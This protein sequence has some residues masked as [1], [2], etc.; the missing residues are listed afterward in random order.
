MKRL[1][2]SVVMTACNHETCIAEAV[3]SVLSKTRQNIELIIVNDGFT[4]HAESVIL[5][6]NDV[7]IN[8]L[9]QPN[10]G[11]HHAL[12][13]RISLAQGEYIAILN[14]DDVFIENRLKILLDTLQ[15]DKLNFLITDI[16]LIDKTPEIISDP[17]RWW[18]RWR[19]ALKQKF[20][21]TLPT[22]AAFLAGNCSATSS[23][24]FLHAQLIKKIGLIRPF[25]YIV[26]YDFAFW[27]A[28]T[29]PAAFSFLID[30]KLLSYRLH[31]SNTISETPLLA[32]IE[33]LYFLK[34]SIIKYFGNKLN[35]L[36]CHLSKVN[37][38]LYKIQK[39]YLIDQENKLQYQYAKFPHQNSQLH[40][41]CM[42]LTRELAL[43]KNLRNYLAGRAIT[44]PY[45]WMIAQW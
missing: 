31:S 37:G 40:N 34:N 2:V 28:L 29:N 43:F 15:R 26:G 42:W 9:S 33:T 35:I 1:Q 27:A 17:S 24:Y 4:G 22:A 36:L 5:G 16:H 25:F 23:D 32:N 38:Y 21:Q 19:E 14:S 30:Q 7:R 11:T 45:R 3:Q 44:A 13:R 41:Y 12:N 6:F 18:L 10:Q 8:Y 39:V 20:Q